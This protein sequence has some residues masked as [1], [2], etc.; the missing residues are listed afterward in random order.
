L[1]KQER[2]ARIFL[3]CQQPLVLQS[4][5]RPRPLPGQHEFDSSPMMGRRPDSGDGMMGPPGPIGP[6]GHQGPAGPTGPPGLPG[7]PGPPGA[8]SK[9]PEYI[10]V[11]GPPG[12]PSLRSLYDQL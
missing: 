5:A 12:P 2:C 8:I 4:F 6:M 9:E 1:L 11:P 10:P 3:H 7:P